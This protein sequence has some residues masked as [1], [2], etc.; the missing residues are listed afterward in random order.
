MC[1]SDLVSRD[2][3]S[4]VAL[5]EGPV[6]LALQSGSVA[7]TLSDVNSRYRS[8]GLTVTSMVQSVDTMQL[9]WRRIKDWS[10]VQ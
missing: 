3:A 9:A 4:I 1:V 6:G 8:L 2:P 10:Q 7:K 5:I